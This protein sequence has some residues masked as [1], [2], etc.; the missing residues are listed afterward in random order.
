MHSAEKADALKRMLPS[1]MLFSVVWSLGASCDKGGRAAFDRHLREHIQHR[2]SSGA[3]LLH[4]D[5]MFPEVSGVVHNGSQ[6]ILVSVKPT[7]PCRI[8]PC[9]F[10]CHH[11]H[12]A[13]QCTTDALTS[14]SF[15]IN[16]LV[17]VPFP[18]PLLTTAT[19]RLSVRL[20]LRPAAALLG[21]LDEHC[22][23]VQV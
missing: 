11:R 21:G 10:L 20:V 22:P 16:L 1:L 7:L 2:V 14:G 19:E 12:R 17:S 8:F 9:P 4:P 6:L 18:C 5:A 13:A 3:M 23:R 15:L